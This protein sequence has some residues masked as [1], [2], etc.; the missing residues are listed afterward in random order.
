M[1]IKVNE[2]N[3]KNFIISQFKRVFVLFSLLKLLNFNS[4][5]SRIL[6]LMHLKDISF[7]VIWM[8]SCTKKSP[9]YWC[10]A[11]TS[12]ERASLA[13]GGLIKIEHGKSLSSF[14][15]LTLKCLHQEGMSLAAKNISFW[16]YFSQMCLCLLFVVT[17]NS[18]HLVQL[19][20]EYSFQAWING[21]PLSR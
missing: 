9:S 15:F 17:L 16:G 18:K 10:A 19:W 7:Q 21:Q 20:W 4:V 6:L 14:I 2:F 11:P 1:S 5:L 13:R 3:Q 8:Q 12:L